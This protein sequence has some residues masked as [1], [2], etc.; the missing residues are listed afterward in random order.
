ME[1]ISKQ[2]ENYYKIV[3]K[4]GGPT[5]VFTQAIVDEYEAAIKEDKEEELKNKKVNVQFIKSTGQSQ[6]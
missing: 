3:M 4:R 2:L 5:G 6:K 1:N